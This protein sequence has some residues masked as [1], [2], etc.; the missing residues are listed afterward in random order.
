MAIPNYEKDLLMYY[1]IIRYYQ[2]NAGTCILFIK[3]NNVLG[4][5]N[6]NSVKGN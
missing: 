6:R 4:D 1:L 2:P 5:L 3:F